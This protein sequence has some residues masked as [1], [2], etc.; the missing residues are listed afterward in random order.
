VGN[1]EITTKKSIKYLGVMI[2]KDL[3]MTEHIK[4][5][6]ER[7]DK[8]IATLTR[9]MPSE[10]PRP[11]SE[12]RK[13]L[14]SVAESIILYGSV[15]WEPAL[16]IKKYSDLLTRCQRKVVL[17]VISAYKTVSTAALLV[18]AGTPPIDL[19]ARERNEIHKKG[20]KKR[21]EEREKTYKK[22]QER[23]DRS[24]EGAR[25]RNLILSIKEWIENGATGVDHYTSQFLTGHGSF[26]S[27]LQR[28][29]KID[30]AECAYCAEEEDTPEHLLTCPRWK[31]EMGNLQNVLGE[32]LTA[33]NFRRQVVKGKWMEIS[34][35]IK[36]IMKIKTT[37]EQK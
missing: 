29:K 18:T 16:K 20:V 10:G 33:D 22:W 8:T 13:I 24:K 36:K 17:R 35:T 15:I 2:D 28:I 32:E 25:T 26:G 31:D 23:W 27:Y 34:K 21:K 5:T 4:K 11:S 37:E 14:A 3:K 30:R 9:I 6:T 7:V 12:K 1:T 19:L